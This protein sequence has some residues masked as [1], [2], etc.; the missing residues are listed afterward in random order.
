MNKTLKQLSKEYYELLNLGEIM[1]D[2]YSLSDWILEQCPNKDIKVIS[3]L[4]GGTSDRLNYI[5]DDMDDIDISNCNLTIKQLIKDNITDD[6]ELSFDIKD[7]II[8]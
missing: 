1:E 7:I 5:L 2:Q 4:W 6:D 3:Y 8:E